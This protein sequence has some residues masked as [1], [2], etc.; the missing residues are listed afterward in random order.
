MRLIGPSVY[1]SPLWRAVVAR[2]PRAAR[3]WARSRRK[4]QPQLVMWYP[5]ATPPPPATLPDA[6]TLR[7]YREGDE[8]RWLDLL[9][10]NGELGRWDLTRLRHDNAGMVYEALFFV[11][12]GERLVATAG[13]CDREHLGRAVWEIGWVARDPAFRGQR[14]GRHATVAA[15]GAALRLP[16]RPILLKT[17]DHRLPAIRTYLDLGF[18]ADR[19]GD[20]SFESRWRRIDAALAGRR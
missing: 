10:A 8:R 7:T 16:P 6:F 5:S 13:V 15:L 3:V 9:N 17:D 14:L 1:R 18:R 20:L 2:L 4:W 11:C 19:E 12:A